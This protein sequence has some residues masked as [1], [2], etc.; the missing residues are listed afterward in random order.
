MLEPRAVD[1]YITAYCLKCKSNLSHTVVE[2]D[3]D[4]AYLVACNA[5]GNKHPYKLRLTPPKP[6]VARAKKGTTPSLPVG[7]RWE[8]RIA[9]AQ[10]TELVYTMG[11]VYRIGDIV[12][13]EQFGKG[14]VLKLATNKCHVLFQDKERAMAS[15]N[16]S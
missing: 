12:L 7:A 8:A 4:T 14:V 13:H 6:R 11:A 15:A 1:E 10:G 9:A 5:C 3:G 16:V 2:R